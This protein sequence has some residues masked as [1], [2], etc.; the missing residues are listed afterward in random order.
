ML[1]RQLLPTSNNS[2]SVLTILDGAK[3]RRTL[4]CSAV[5]S[6]NTELKIKPDLATV[7]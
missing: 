6:I 2:R 3:K 7:K 5:K 4:A 1:K